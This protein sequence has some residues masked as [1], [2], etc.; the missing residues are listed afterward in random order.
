MNEK[1]IQE[2]FGALEEQ[3]EK[4]REE[5]RRVEAE[6]KKEREERRELEERVEEL[7][8]QFSENVDRLGRNLAQNSGRISDL[9]ETVEETADATGV[10]IPENATPI[11]QIAALPQH[12]AEEQ[13]DNSTHRNTF[14]SRTILRSWSKLSENTPRGRVLSSPE[15]CKVLSTVEEQP[16]ES[17]TGIRVIERIADL[18]RDKFS[19][20]RPAES[21]RG[22]HLV[23]LEP[24]ATLSPPTSGGGSV[25]TE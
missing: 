18:G 24:D 15:I 7:E 10:E 14:R 25:V 21:K 13:F 2:R 16:I 9:E 4:E 17:K 3:I 20:V 12:V 11:E 19:H 5:R 6:L 23:V 8:T 1:E 22:E